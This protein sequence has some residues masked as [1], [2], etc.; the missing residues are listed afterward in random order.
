MFK[1]IYIEITNICNLNCKF[2]PKSDRDKK[3]MTVTEFETIINKINGHTKHIY[4][5][6]KGEPLIHP[7]LDKIIKIANENNINVN[8]TT[9]GRLLKDKLDIINNNK[10]RQINISLH[11]FNSLDEVKDIVK[12]CDSIKNTFINFRLWNDLD[13]NEIFDYLD[14]HYKVNIDRNSLRNNLNDH[15]F[16]SIDKEFDWPSMDLSVIS[17]IGTCRALKDQIGILVNGDVVSCCLD[18]NGDNKLGNIY[19]QDL[20][21]IIN[22]NKYQEMLNGF[23]RCELVSPLCQ[24]CGYR[25]RFK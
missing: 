19:K 14:E 10:I 2:C 20:D 22:S 15:I 8:I 12:L 13:N 17:R 9:N 24:R 7:D 11:S 25:E 21:E 16:L 1:R 5:H 6:I 23:N 3:V 18:N 4:L